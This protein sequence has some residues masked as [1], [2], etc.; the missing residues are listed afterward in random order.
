MTYK[1]TVE[2]IGFQNDPSF[3]VVRT[4][5][6]GD[7]VSVHVKLPRRLAPGDLGHRLV[8]TNPPISEFDI[9][10]IVRGEVIAKAQRAVKAF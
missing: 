10:E 2:D 4:V 5:E 9:P 6:G 8:S 3:R 1:V 7:M